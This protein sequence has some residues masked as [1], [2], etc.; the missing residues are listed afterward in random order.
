MSASDNLPPGVMPHMIPGNENT[1]WGDE[2]EPSRPDVEGL[3]AT[4]IVGEQIV[5][6]HVVDTGYAPDKW[7]FDPEVTRVFDDMLERSIPDYDKMRNW[8][9]DVATAFVQPGTLVVDLGCSRGE[10]LERVLRACPAGPQYLGAEISGPM[11]GA[12]RER[13]Q[14]ED[15]VE[16][17]QWDLRKGYP[18]RAR[19]VS[20]TLCVLT[21]MFVPVNYRLQLVGETWEQTIPGGAMILVEKVLGSGPKTDDV[22]QANYHRLKTEQGY[23]PDDVERKRLSLEGQLVP[24]TA[25][26]NVQL[27]RAGGFE[28]VE[29]FWAWGPFRAWM[30]VKR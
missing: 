26:W 27:L 25:D 10:A 6:G 12:A 21:M 19:P 4:S 16:I 15:L 13:F 23:T 22:L 8:V 17:R 11:L 28:E 29:L 18:E 2:L 1:G 5:E 30:A 7:E 24:L 14:A 9:T 20:L 3:D